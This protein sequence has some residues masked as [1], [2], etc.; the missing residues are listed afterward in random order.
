VIRQLSG[1]LIH[2]GTSEVVISCDGVG[3][4]VVV[5]SNTPLPP[6]G[7]R[8]T[9]WTHLRVREDA[10]DLFGFAS[11]DELELFESMQGIHRFPAKSALAVLSHLGVEGFLRAVSSGDVDAL[12]T[13]PGVGKKTAQQLLLEIRGHIDLTKLPES[14][15]AKSDL[16]DAGLALVELGYAE[17]E[18]RDRVAAVRREHTSVTDVAEILKLALQRGTKR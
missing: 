16:D 17:S 2:R 1:T 7:E 11:R 10:L 9:L 6:A 13:I 15:S 4:G 8:V 12:T 14:R 18:A 3:Y 5:P